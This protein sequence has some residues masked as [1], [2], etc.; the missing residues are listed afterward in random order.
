MFDETSYFVDAVV[1][2]DRIRMIG[3]PL[4]KFFIIARKTKEIVFFFDILGF[5]VVNLALV[6]V[7][8]F[9]V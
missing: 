1:G 5:R 7:E 3:I 9:G 2:L 4:E 8:F 6:V